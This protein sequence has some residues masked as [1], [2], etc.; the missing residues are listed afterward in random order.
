MPTRRSAF[1]CRHTSAASGS[2]AAACLASNERRVPPDDSRPVVVGLQPLDH[3]ALF[4]GDRIVVARD[5]HIEHRLQERGLGT[6]AL[7]DQLR[8]DTRG[9][10]DGRDRRSRVAVREEHLPRRIEHRGPARR[11]LRPPAVRV[12][13]AARFDIFRHLIQAPVEKY[14]QL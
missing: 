6:E 5:R 12:V 14:S 13:A 4:E 10:R 1:I 11:R 3:F 8:R 9:A 2:A 7:V